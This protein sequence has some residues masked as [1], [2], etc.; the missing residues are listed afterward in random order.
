[1]LNNAWPDIIK[2]F[3]LIWHPPWASSVPRW[4][5]EYWTGEKNGTKNV[6]THQY[7]GTSPGENYN[8]SVKTVNGELTASAI[9]VAMAASLISTIRM[10][11]MAWFRFWFQ[12][13]YRGS[14][15]GKTF[16]FLCFIWHRIST[17]LS[18]NA[19]LEHDGAKDRSWH[20]WHSCLTTV[21]GT[22]RQT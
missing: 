13:Y 18:E 10:M 14:I 12:F 20:N 17:I 1:M 9:F 15:N 4:Y 5:E 21:N 8:K 16:S 22:Q 2:G 11:T 6:R 3:F 7:I 19:I